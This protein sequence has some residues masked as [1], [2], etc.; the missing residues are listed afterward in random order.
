MVV[1]SQPPFP[2]KLLMEKM[3]RA[4]DASGLTNKRYRPRRIQ[5]TRAEKKEEMVRLRRSADLEHAR[6]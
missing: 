2:L 1:V 4:E 5:Q 3:E 6:R